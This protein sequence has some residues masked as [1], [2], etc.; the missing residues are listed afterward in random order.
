MPSLHTQ[1][2]NHEINMPL[3]HIQVNGNYC[4]MTTMDENVIR[5]KLI[6]LLSNFFVHLTGPLQLR[7]Y[8]Y[9]KT[10]NG[11]LNCTR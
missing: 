11:L 7:M 9:F 6:H 1:V 3:L 5:M 8:N 10:L 2:K 4:H